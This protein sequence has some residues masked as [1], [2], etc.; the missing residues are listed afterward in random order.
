D[1]FFVEFHSQ[2]GAVGH[3]DVA[4]VYDGLRGPADQVAPPRDVHRVIFHC[5]HVSDCRCHVDGGETADRRTGEVDG[6]LHAV[7][8]GV[9]GDALGFANGARGERVR[10]DDIDGAVVDQVAE[11]LF[12]TEQALAGCDRGG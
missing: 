2:A 10:V 9:I 5:E 3:R 7:H 12:E 8:R 6:S 11:A 4:V 1:D